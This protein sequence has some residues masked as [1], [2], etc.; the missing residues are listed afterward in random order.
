M[1]CLSIPDVLNL[2]KEYNISSIDSDVLHTLQTFVLS[3]FANLML[4]SCACTCFNAKRKY[5]NASDIMKATIVIKMLHGDHLFEDIDDVTLIQRTMCAKMIHTQ[6]EHVK[7][8]L[9]KTLGT[10]VHVKISSDIVHDLQFA[11]NTC[12]VNYT[13]TYLRSLKGQLGQSARVMRDMLHSLLCDGNHLDF[14]ESDFKP[15]HKS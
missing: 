13:K 10:D 9:S 15:F 6:L 12:L 1:S 11:M 7:H 3:R 2:F 14:G 5:I 4:K 8:C